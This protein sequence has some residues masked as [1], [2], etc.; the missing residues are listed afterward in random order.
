MTK[1]TEMFGKIQKKDRLWKAQ[2]ERFRLVV[3]LFLH[4]TKFRDL[5]I[6]SL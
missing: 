4:S 3:N 2:N 1:V 6:S 5:L